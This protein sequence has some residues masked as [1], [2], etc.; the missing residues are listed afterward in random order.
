[1]SPCRP[2]QALELQAFSSAAS[3]NRAPPVKRILFGQ[4]RTPRHS[5]PHTS[6]PIG[7][8]AS[9]DNPIRR[10]NADIAAIKPRPYRA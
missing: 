2:A 9:N 3:G 6:R 1:M 4:P 10:R 7:N 8:A 5:Q